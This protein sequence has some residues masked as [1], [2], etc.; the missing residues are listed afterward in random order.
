MRL[1]INHMQ[2]KICLNIIRYKREL[3]YKC[4]LRFKCELQVKISHACNC[5]LMKIDYIL[6]INR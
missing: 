4:E 6:L 1:L 2:G 3:R 5:M